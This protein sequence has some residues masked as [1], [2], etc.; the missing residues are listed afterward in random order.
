MSELLAPEEIEAIRQYVEAA[1]PGPWPVRRS[2]LD[3]KTREVIR[4]IG[5]VET[6][7]FLDDPYVFCETWLSISDADAEFISRVREDVPRLLR[8]I[9]AIARA[10]EGQGGGPRP[11]LKTN[12][13]RGAD[14][15]GPQATS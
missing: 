7:V 2:R 11:H 13:E 4:G 3:G 12:K 15:E 8:H 9:A 5:P 10:E 14:I 1:T 6:D